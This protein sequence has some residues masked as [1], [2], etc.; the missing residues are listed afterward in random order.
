MKLNYIV[1]LDD[2]RLAWGGELWLQPLGRDDVWSWVTTFMQSRRAN[3]G[4]SNI[5][6]WGGLVGYLGYELGLE[7]LQVPVMHRKCIS[8]GRYPDMNL[9]FVTRSIVVYSLSVEV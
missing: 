6:F 2:I 5:P 3:D 1:G 7:S 8:R 9:V 4:P